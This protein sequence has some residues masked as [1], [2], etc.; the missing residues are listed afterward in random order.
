MIQDT[1]DKGPE[2]V[3]LFA[4]CLT[5]TTVATI[6]RVYVRA[7]LIKN[8]GIDDWTAVIGWVRPY[9]CVT[10]LANRAGLFCPLNS[11]S[12]GCR[13]L[14]RWSTQQFCRASRA[15]VD[16]GHGMMSFPSSGVANLSS[17]CGYL[18]MHTFSVPWLSN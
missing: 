7:F 13:C 16:C 12:A 5:I 3:I 10:N 4:I 18:S 9:A 11:V 15:C 6:L 1:S 14:W 17:G 8:F 2:L